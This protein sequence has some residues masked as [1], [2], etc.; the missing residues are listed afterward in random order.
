MLV[1]SPRFSFSVS[2]ITEDIMILQGEAE[3]KET[4]ELVVSTCCFQ[5][6]SFDCP[7]NHCPVTTRPLR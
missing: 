1:G 2:Y 3:V 5:H 7:E 4:K 6:C